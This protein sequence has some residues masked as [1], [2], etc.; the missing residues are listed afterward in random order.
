MVIADSACLDHGPESRSLSR[1][2]QEDARPGGAQPKQHA[3]A[4]AG[5]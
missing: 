4:R 1:L 5:V 3:H 2:L